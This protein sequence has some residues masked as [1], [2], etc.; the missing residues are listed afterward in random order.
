MNYVSLTFIRP[1][2]SKTIEFNSKIFL[3][4]NQYFPIWKIDTSPYNSF[5]FF[6]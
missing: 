3:N 4:K 5:K 1:A 2:N 6:I